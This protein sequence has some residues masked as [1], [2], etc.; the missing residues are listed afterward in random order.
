MTT[1]KKGRPPGAGYD[2]YLA[3]IADIIV[4]SGY[5]TDFATA[6]RELFPLAFKFHV[7]REAAFKRINE[8]WA[9][10]GQELLAVAVKR[11]VDLALM[12]E[13]MELLR[14]SKVKVSA[15]CEMSEFAYTMVMPPATPENYTA[16][17][18]VQAAMSY[19]EYQ[20]AYKLRYIEQQQNKTTKL[21]S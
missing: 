10:R 13:A 17:P 14:L 16:N 1:K 3:D 20:Q 18:F 11:K 6:K 2:K 4:A 12:A 9:E 8:L 7:T 21:V 5:T 19:G 15:I